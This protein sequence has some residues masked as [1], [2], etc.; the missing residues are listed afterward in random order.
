MKKVYII[1][2]VVV[3]SASWLQGM[4]SGGEGV[5]EKAYKN[6]LYQTPFGYNFFLEEK[7]KAAFD[8]QFEEGATSPERRLVDKHAALAAEAAEAAERA[9]GKERSAE[10]ED[11]VVSGSEGSEVISAEEASSEGSVGIA[12]EASAEPEA[13]EGV[14]FIHRMVKMTILF[15]SV[16]DVV[17]A[18]ERN[19]GGRVNAADVIA[20]YQHYNKLDRL[21]SLV[22]DEGG[23]NEVL[24][25]RS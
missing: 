1:S 17:R 21:W 12:S 10:G 9:R 25:R 13:G 5:L 19:A 18:M 24:A 23:L 7:F 6:A 14:P 15:G 2:L 4:D 22:G 20:T 8:K 11:G 3:A 16:P